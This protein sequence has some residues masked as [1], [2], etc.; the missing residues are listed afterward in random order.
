MKKY[1]ATCFLFLF[2]L[3][4]VLSQVLSAEQIYAKINN[5]VVTIYTFDGNEKLLA[6]GSG[7]VLNGKGWVV[8]NYHVYAGAEKIVVKHKDKIVKYTGIIGLDV[9]KDILILKIADHAFPAITMGNSDR[10]N[11]GQKIYAIGSPMGFENSI[12]EGI[13]S[14]LRSNEERTK[15]FIQISAAI[16]PGSSGG[17]V[18]DATG[19]LIGITTLSVIKGQNLNFAIPVNEVLLAYKQAGITPKELSASVYLDKGLSEYNQ[20]NTN[21]AINNFLKAIEIDPKYAQAYNNLGCIYSDKSDLETA[22]FYLKKAIE[23]NPNFAEAYYNIGNAYKRKKEIEN[24]IIYYKK[25]ISINPR[26]TSAYFNLGNTYFEINQLE[27]AILYAQKAIEIDPQKAEAYVLLGNIYLQKKIFENAITY[28][29]EAISINPKLAVAYYNLGTVYIQKKDFETSTTYFLKAISVNPDYMNA[30]YNL[31][32]AYY[33][34]G[35][36]YLKKGEIESAID[37]FKKTINT[38]PKYA[39]GYY[40][41][42]I[43]YG[44]KGDNNMKDYFLQK[45]YELD[46][47][48]RNR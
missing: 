10:L 47:T 24:S 3:N 26:Y 19:K 7:V 30:Y 34:I 43:A 40:A 45:A 36:D 44:K 35:A 48:L 12:T 20:N 33:S 23:I 18:V 9:E 31:A 4:S 27:T 28:Y 8:T 21:G 1:I 22:F 17:A 5:A 13:I 46:P 29:K 2:S 42:G 41:L 39:N 37:Y 32:I 14:G 6:Q 15:N 25:A 16:S 11:I 38:N